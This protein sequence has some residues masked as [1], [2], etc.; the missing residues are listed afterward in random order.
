MFST[1]SMHSIKYKR[2]QYTRN[3]ETGGSRHKDGAGAKQICPKIQ[4]CDEMV[5]KVWGNKRKTDSGDLLS[6]VLLEPFTSDNVIQVI[7]TKYAC[8]CAHNTNIFI[9]I[10]NFCLNVQIMLLLSQQK[11]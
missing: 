10:N 8:M 7:K 3:R 5:I 2:L 4:R 6:S 1:N 9:I 11:F